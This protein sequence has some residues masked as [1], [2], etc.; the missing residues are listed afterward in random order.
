MQEAL[1]R[2]DF[3]IDNYDTHLIPAQEEL[4]DFTSKGV[5]HNDYT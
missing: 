4:K 3:K 1:D 5:I 2:L